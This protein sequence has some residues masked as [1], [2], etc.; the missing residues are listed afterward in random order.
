MWFIFHAIVIFAVMASIIRWH[1]TPNGYVAGLL[2]WLAALLLT[3]GL[4]GLG[5]LLRRWRAWRCQT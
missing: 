3:V 4:N 5:D 1:W 2:G